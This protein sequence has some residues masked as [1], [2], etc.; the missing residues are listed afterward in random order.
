MSKSQGLSN[1]I[2]DKTIHIGPFALVREDTEAAERAFCSANVRAAL[3]FSHDPDKEYCLPCAS[4]HPPNA[5]VHASTNVLQLAFL[6]T[7]C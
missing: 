3:P 1:S 7:E 5:S 6:L 2:C 4:N